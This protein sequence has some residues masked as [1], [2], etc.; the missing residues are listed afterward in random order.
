MPSYVKVSE[1]GKYGL[2]APDSNGYSDLYRIVGDKPA[3]WT[4]EDGPWV[5]Y[6]IGAVGDP[7]NFET[8]IDN[9][10]EEMRVLVAQ[11]REEFG[12]S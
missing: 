1:D 10:E 3:D 9:A 5:D 6:M 12:L 7:E 4:D 8:A 11:A 2:T